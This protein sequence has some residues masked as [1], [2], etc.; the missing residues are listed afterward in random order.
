MSFE[1]ELRLPGS[2]PYEYV[3]I[4]VKGDTIAE[5]DADLDSVSDELVEKL[6][7]IHRMAADIMLARKASTPVANPQRTTVVSA[8]DLITTELGGTVISET[9]NVKPWE[10]A[11]PAA[12]SVNLF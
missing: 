11:K 6:R 5:F 12:Q 7:G 10:R 3:N 1:T 9:E 4:T 8:T 2:K